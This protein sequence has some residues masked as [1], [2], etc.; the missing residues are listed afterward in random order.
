VRSQGAGIDY[1]HNFA[2]GFSN[3][4]EMAVEHS[5]GIDQADKLVDRLSS[6]FPRER[7]YRS[8]VSPVLGVHAGPNAIAVTV[9]EA[10]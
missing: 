8:T 10:D 6:V 7:I 4:K 2:V 1:L 9:L 5:T 3:I